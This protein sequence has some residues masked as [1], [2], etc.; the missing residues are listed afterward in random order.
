M[1]P[2]TPCVP[3][4]GAHIRRAAARGDAHDDVARR[5]TGR[6]E[7]AHGVLLAVLGALLCARQRRRSPGDDA[8]HHRRVRAKGGRALGG[9][10]HAEAPGGAG[11]DV[12]QAMP[13]AEGRLHQRDGPRHGLALR[14]HRVGNRAVLRVHQVHDLQRRREIDVDAT[15]VSSLGDPGIEHGAEG[16]EG[17]AVSRVGW[18][19]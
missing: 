16:G 12:E 7:I 6:G 4:R 17:V 15:R 9:V 3:Q 10:E 8:L 18:P 19:P 2:H 11:T 5:D 14:R 1:G 13:G